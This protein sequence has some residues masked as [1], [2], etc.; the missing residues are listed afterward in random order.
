MAEKS[1][2]PKRNIQTLDIP[3]PLE[4]EIVAALEELPGRDRSNVLKE[5]IRIGLP[6]IVR[7][8]KRAAA[9]A[10]ASV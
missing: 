5:A 10:L 9:E 4:K 6:A 8:S 2:A 7:A 3:D 1:E